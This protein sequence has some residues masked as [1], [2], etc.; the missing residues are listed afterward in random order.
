[1]AET[2][3]Q[4]GEPEP[5]FSY[6][7]WSALFDQPIEVPFDGWMSVR[8][9]R[10]QTGWSDDRVRMWLHKMAR[11]GR[12]LH[13]RPMRLSELDGLMHPSTVYRVLKET[14]RQT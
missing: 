3:G 7:D 14:A 6:E 9:I 5:G 13:K 1:M 2:D 10:E 4:Q 11:Q 8:E 12:L